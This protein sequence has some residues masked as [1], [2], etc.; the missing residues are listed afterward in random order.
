MSG[1]ETAATPQARRPAHAAAAPR[2]QT[3]AHSDDPRPC[4]RGSGDADAG[5][6]GSDGGGLGGRGKG[7]TP[8][9]SEA[10]VV[11]Q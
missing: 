1:G 9:A 4:A 2:A 11:R 10:A 6:R 5:A 7:V 8:V 3:P